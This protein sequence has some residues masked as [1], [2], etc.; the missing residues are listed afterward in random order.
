MRANERETDTPT[1][2][3]TTTTDGRRTDTTH[4]VTARVSE[5]WAASGG[6]RPAGGG[7]PT[8][9]DAGIKSATQV[10][11]ARRNRARLVCDSA[12]YKGAETTVFCFFLPVCH[13]A[14]FKSIWSFFVWFLVG[15]DRGPV[16]IS[17]RK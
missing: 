6:R 12:R 7:R 17:M 16:V 8:D 10:A 1:D 9:A 3:D 5:R 13:G 15:K 2:T 4:N 11:T 14:F